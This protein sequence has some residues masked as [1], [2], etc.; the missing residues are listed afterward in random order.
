[1]SVEPGLG[2]Q[3]FIKESLEKISALRKKIDENNY[4]ILI[5]VDGGINENTGLECVDAGADILVAGTYL[6]HQKDVKKRIETLK[7]G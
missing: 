5:E 2:G 7:R 1:M 6:F 4:D 3:S